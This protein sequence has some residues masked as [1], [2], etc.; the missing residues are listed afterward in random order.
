MTRQR[1]ETHFLSNPTT[2]VVHD[3]LR[4]VKCVSVVS[5]SPNTFDVVLGQQH[6]DSQGLWLYDR[7]QMMTMRTTAGDN[8]T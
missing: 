5:R 1:R 3:V 4:Y 7:F 8:L 6:R 2:I